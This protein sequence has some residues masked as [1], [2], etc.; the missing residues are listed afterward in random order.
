M[1][2][3]PRTHVSPARRLHDAGVSL[4][5]DDLSRDLIDDG[6]LSRYLAEHGISGVT[7]N[8]TIF[9]SALQA[10]AGYDEQLRGL[11]HMGPVVPQEAYFALALADVR[12]AAR[13]LSDVHARSGGRDGYVSFECT[14]DVAD[15]ADA[16]VRQAL[17]VRRRVTAPNLMVKVPGTA[18][19]MLAI[20][21]LTAAG[22]NVNVTLLFTASQYEQA[23][24]A[25]QRGLSQRLAAGDEVASVR[26]VAS[27]FVSRLDAVVDEIL[28]YGSRLLGRAGI[29]NGQRIAARARALARTRTW[30]KL[31]NA[32]AHPQRVLWASTAT[33]GPAYRDVMYVEGLALLDT[34]ITMPEPTLLAFADHGRPVLANATP[35]RATRLLH[36]LE[37]EGIDID[38]VGAQLLADGL[39]RFARDYD[40]ALSMIG[41]KITHHSTHA[42]A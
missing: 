32:G 27:I 13:V 37:T 38:D 34:I 17:A 19:G 20:E 33:K 15:N 40:R 14:P 35:T 39:D 3:D 9:A 12:Q 1:E 4:W 2:P 16:T 7:C 28:P 8:P 5:L 30:T 18:A 10:S 29:A 23:E 31:K 25:F 26:S 42:A 22:V 21:E 36:D 41:A 11:L 6:V 24:R